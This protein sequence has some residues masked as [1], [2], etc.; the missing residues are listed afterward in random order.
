MCAQIWVVHHRSDGQK[1]LSLTSLTVGQSQVA[2]AFCPQTAAAA[3]A[4]TCPSNVRARDLNWTGASQEG[5]Q[6]EL[7][8]QFLTHDWRSSELVH[9]SGRV[10]DTNRAPVRDSGDIDGCFPKSRA[11]M[12]PPWFGDRHWHAIQALGGGA[13]RDDGGGSRRGTDYGRFLVLA[14]N[15]PRATISEAR[16][17]IHPSRRFPRH[18]LDLAR[19]GGAAATSLAP[20]VSL[21]QYLFSDLVG[22]LRLPK[23]LKNMI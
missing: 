13:A 2:A 17:T 18:P 11:C 4:G 21:S 1:L 15:S 20:S 10:R 6:Q 12:A 8:R 23:V 5:G 7:H 22:G 19:W 3:M 16:A 9:G 14:R